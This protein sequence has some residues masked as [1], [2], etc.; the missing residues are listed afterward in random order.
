MCWLCGDAIHGYG[1]FNGGSEGCKGGLFGRTQGEHLPHLYMFAHHLTNRQRPQV[2]Y[3]ILKAKVSYVK[4]VCSR[5]KALNGG[6]DH[7][8]GFRA[9]AEGDAKEP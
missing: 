6:F 9:S 2:M 7:I 4:S 8:S 1:H 5:Q 3:L